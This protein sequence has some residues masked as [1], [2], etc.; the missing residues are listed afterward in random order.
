MNTID[1]FNLKSFDLNL[2]VAFDALMQER[3]VTQAAVK[4]HIQQPAM[5][6]S[7]STLR[8]LFDDELFVRVKQSLQP[9][10]RAL[11]LREPVRVAL[12]QAQDILRRREV[13]D[14]AIVERT[15]RIGMTN[16]LEV[17]LLP[18]LTAYCGRE[19]PGIKL[20]ARS[21][22]PQDAPAMLDAGEIDLAVGCYDRSEPWLRQ[23]LLFEETVTCCFNP[24][25]LRVSNPIGRRAYQEMPHV[26]VSMRDSLAG[27]LEDSLAEI[28]EELNVVSAGPNFLAV[29]KMASECP[30]LTTVPSRIASYYAPMF[31][32]EMSPVPLPFPLNPISMS[33]HVRAHREP[34]NEWLR[35]CIRHSH[36]DGSAEHLRASNQR[37][38]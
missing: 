29:L 23:E 25:L 17:L 6:H 20:L 32:L 16:G 7:L 9:T 37:V 18:E 27:C 1:H 34:G 12:A 26:V 8:V 19:S 3:S 35:S 38:A 10:E 11:A 36:L 14:P 2:L 4:L 21:V 22:D 28:G 33:W 31:G 13:F 15:F 24:D 30:V 5:S